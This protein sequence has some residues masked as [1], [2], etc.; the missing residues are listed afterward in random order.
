MSEKWLPYSVGRTRPT[1]SWKVSST[2]VREGARVSRL[3]HNLRHSFVSRMAEPRASDATIMSL[4]G[5][6]LAG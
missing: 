4:A 6:S 2:A 1:G 3:W 5:I